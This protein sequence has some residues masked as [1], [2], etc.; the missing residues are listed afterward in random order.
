MF[1]G[2]GFR[3][4]SLGLKVFK[5]LGFRFRARGSRALDTNLKS[6]KLLS[7]KLKTKA[8]SPSQGFNQ[9][10]VQDWQSL[11]R[12]VGGLERNHSFVLGSRLSGSGFRVLGFRV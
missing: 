7:L 10:E 12:Q 11:C 4:S 8:L 9:L 6:F 2:S 3:V 5:D 1:K